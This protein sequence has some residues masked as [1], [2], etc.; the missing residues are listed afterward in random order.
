VPETAA[1]SRFRIFT[2]YQNWH[3]VCPQK[4]LDIGQAFF[5]DI[6]LIT[7]VFAGTDRL[8]IYVLYG[9][10]LWL[11]LGIY[12][13]LYGIV[14]GAIEIADWVKEKKRGG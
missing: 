4:R 2:Y 5:D 3:I 7:V 10:N 12:I 6:L 1:D 14:L 13:V 9:E 11:E 8:M